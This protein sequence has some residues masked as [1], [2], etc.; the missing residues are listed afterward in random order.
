M[1]HPQRTTEEAAAEHAR[2]SR[3][4]EANTVPPIAGR[5]THTFVVSPPKG[6]SW[7]QSQ[8]LIS[9]DPFYTPRGVLPQW[10]P[11]KAGSPLSRLLVGDVVSKAGGTYLLAKGNQNG[12]TALVE[13]LHASPGQVVLQVERKWEVWMDDY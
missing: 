5:D 12:I 1:L 13:L 7:A 6:R 10:S 8:L 9:V 4:E 11:V 3:N 2:F